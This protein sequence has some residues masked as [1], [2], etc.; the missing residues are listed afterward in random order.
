MI[1]PNPKHLFEDCLP[2]LE[3]SEPE[4]FY[5]HPVYDLKCNQI[6]IIYKEEALKN[7]SYSIISDKYSLSD[8]K[9]YK[10][11]VPRLKLLAQCFYGSMDIKP[12][13]VPLDGNPIN[14]TPENLVYP[15]ELNRKAK[16]NYNEFKQ[17]TLM[18]M[19]E[20]DK[21]LQKTGID[22][23]HYWALLKLINPFRDFYS[24]ATGYDLTLDE[25]G[26]PKYLAEE[27]RNLV[28]AK[29]KNIPNQYRSKEEI[30]K[31]RKQVKEMRATGMKQQKVAEILGIHPAM[32]GY[33]YKSKD[34]KSKFS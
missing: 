12:R 19:L 18:Y 24:A 25:S 21:D 22:P 31:L 17:Q 4:I 27:K 10:I 3:D 26:A 13:I 23:Q 16:A 29:Q 30:S 20:R 11:A 33:L 34:H 8:L 2:R 5:K 32:A 1:I 28:K 15:K 14:T 7:F 9:N 6:G